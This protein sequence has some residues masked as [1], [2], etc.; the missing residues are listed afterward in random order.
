MGIAARWAAITR[1]IIGTQIAL[2]DIERP[3]DHG[4]ERQ[5]EGN[6]HAPSFK[7]VHNPAEA[8]HRNRSVLICLGVLRLLER[9]QHPHENSGH[10][11]VSPASWFVTDDA[12]DVT[13]GVIVATQ[14]DV[15]GD[16]HSAIYSN[17]ECRIQNAEND[18]ASS[19]ASIVGDSHAKSRHRYAVARPSIAL[20][21]AVQDSR[22]E[23]L[24]RWASISGTITVVGR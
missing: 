15:E 22:S 14:P 20:M 3:R 2:G 13:G 8:A 11:I 19:P 4:P 10:I 1:W 24:P 6:D 21:L 18:D 17:A 16:L 9:T 5:L 7:G 23:S 12:D